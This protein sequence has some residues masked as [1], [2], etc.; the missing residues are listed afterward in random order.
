MFTTLDRDGD[1]WASGNCAEYLHGAWW[2]LNCQKS[3]LNG[4]YH[5]SGYYSQT[6]KDGVVWHDWTG[7]DYSLPFTEMKIR[8]KA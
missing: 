2:Y 3:N 5:S 8:P 4:R 6:N 7:F 1:D